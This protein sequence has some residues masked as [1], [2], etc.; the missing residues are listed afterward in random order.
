MYLTNGSFEILIDRLA[1]VRAAYYTGML[2]FW[3]W[4]L[5]DFINV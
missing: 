1:F 4:R 5:W 3:N 2:R